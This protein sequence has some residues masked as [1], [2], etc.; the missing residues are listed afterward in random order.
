MNLHR[1]DERVWPLTVA[2]EQ[3]VYLEK[4]GVPL[5]KKSPVLQLLQVLLKMCI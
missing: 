4:L 5:Y 1:D 2:V 3:H